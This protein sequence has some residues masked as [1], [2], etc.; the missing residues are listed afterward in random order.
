MKKSKWNELEIALLVLLAVCLLTGA[1]SLR[2]Q[3]VLQQ[4]MIRL[5]VVANSDSDRDQTLKLQVRDKV[6]AFTEQTMRASASREE[7]NNAL[8]EA[9]PQIKSMAED[10]LRENDCSDSVEARLE[11]AEFPLKAYDGFRLPAGEYMAL[12][13]L[14]GEAAGQNW[15]CVVYPP[16]C[17]AAASDVRETGIA[18]GMEQEELSLMQEENEA[19]QVKFRFMELWE[20]LRQWLGKESRILL[21][22]PKYDKVI[23]TSRALCVIM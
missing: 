22:N 6:L 5:H 7:A 23:V 15:W 10:I 3:D 14:I 16:L 19:Y 17:M 20:Q 9:L 12:R 21:K 11:P 1:M 13:V 18:C 2:N 8:R 4:K